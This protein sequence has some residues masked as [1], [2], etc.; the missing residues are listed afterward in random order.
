MVVERH[1]PNRPID[2]RVDERR[3]AVAKSSRR[4]RLILLGVVLALGLVV[5]GMPE[6]VWHSLTSRIQTMDFVSHGHAVRSWER[7]AWLGGL[8]GDSQWFFVVTGFKA[9]EEKQASPNYETEMHTTE[10][11]PD[12]SIMSQ[13][14]TTW[15][16]NGFPHNEW[17]TSPPWWWNVTDQTEPTA[18]WWKREK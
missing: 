15:D 8:V 9:G 1:R 2:S 7:V 11:H 10:W 18:P 17:N 12:G 13:C 14:R 6:G 16:T 5:A 3:R 4:A